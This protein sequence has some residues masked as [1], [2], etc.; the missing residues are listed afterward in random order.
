M[1]EDLVVPAKK[2]T[3]RAGWITL[4]R[5]ITD[6]RWVGLLRPILFF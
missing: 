2:E 3:K 6:R 5:G 4:E 1:A